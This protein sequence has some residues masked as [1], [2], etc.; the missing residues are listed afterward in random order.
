MI[1]SCTHWQFHRITDAADTSLES[2]RDQLFNQLYREH[3]EHEISMWLEREK[4]R[5]HI[6]HLH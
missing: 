6:E 5:A 4:V 2:V 1:S 3:E